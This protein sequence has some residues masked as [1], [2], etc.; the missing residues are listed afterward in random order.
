MNGIFTGKDE[1]HQNKGS[2]IASIVPD[3]EKLQFVEHHLDCW[4]WLQ[5]CWG[6]IDALP[7]KSQM[8]S[9]ATTFYLNSSQ[10]QTHFNLI[11]LNGFC[12]VTLKHIYETSEA[13]YQWLLTLQSITWWWCCLALSGICYEIVLAKVT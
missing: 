1:P 11:L 9:P 6:S 7:D 5:Q 3:F 2:P 13:K 8:T 4:W 12:L 10:I